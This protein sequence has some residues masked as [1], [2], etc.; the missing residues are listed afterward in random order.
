M[1]FLLPE[2]VAH[3]TWVTNVSRMKGWTVEGVGMIRR[4]HQCA[5]QG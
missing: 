5:L 3:K 2:L 4:T 1:F